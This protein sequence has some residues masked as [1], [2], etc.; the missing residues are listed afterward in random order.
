MLVPV[1]MVPV[2]IVEDTPLKTGRAVSQ[3]TTYA[4]DPLE[5]NKA[6]ISS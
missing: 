4:Y 2:N 3:N 5:T 1:V 6:R